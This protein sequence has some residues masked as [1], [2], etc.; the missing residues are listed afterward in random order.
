M[1]ESVLLPPA[2][3]PRQLTE[4]VTE[5]YSN[6]TTDNDLRRQFLLVWW[7]WNVEPDVG[8]EFNNCISQYGELR[9]P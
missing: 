2:P 3:F 7:A 6:I 9:Q 4:I 1:P 5:I 8:G